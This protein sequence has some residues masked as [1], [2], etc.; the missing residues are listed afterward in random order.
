MRGGTTGAGSADIRAVGKAGGNAGIGAD[1]GAAGAGSSGG[2]SSLGS[3]VSS[4]GV[5][6]DD[7]PGRGSGREARAKTASPTKAFSA[8][9][10]CSC[11]FLSRASSTWRAVIRALSCSASRTA[12]PERTKAAMGR[13][14]TTIKSPRS[15]RAGT[16]SIGKNQKAEISRTTVASLHRLKN[17]PSVPGAFISEASNHFSGVVS[18]TLDWR[19]ALSVHP[20]AVGNGARRLYV[21]SVGAPRATER[22][23]QSAGA[24]VS[25][26]GF[27]I[28]RARLCSAEVPAE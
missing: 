20:E 5:A 9:S 16:S 2:G 27:G 21:F 18:I 25:E 15:R 10:C 17:D 19:Q 24:L 26:G 22:G 13:T 7:S 8:E 12:R 6:S 1:S 28:L 3:R 23:L 4:G 14:K 11:E